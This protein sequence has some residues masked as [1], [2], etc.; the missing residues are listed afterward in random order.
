MKKSLLALFVLL[1]LTALCAATP[2]VSGRKLLQDDE[3]EED[4]DSDNSAPAPSVS[5]NSILD[6]ARQLSDLSVFYRAAA[7]AGL[8]D[9]L[10][11]STVQAT[12]F[13]PT[14]DALDDFLENFDLTRTQFINTPAFS[15]LVL[16]YHIVPS[17]ALRASQLSDNQRLT[18][19]LNNYRITINTDRDNE[20]DDDSD[21]EV[22]A[23][24]SDA[25]IERADI[26]AG[27][28]IVHTIG[29]V[30]IPRRGFWLS[31][32]Q[33]QIGAPASG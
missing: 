31:I 13:A 6:A 26:V 2:L 24:H 8:N 20:D 15:R 18:T 32:V 4:G 19:A 11:S 27:Q 23:A 3:D 9:T 10:T 28:A 25:E 16:Q 17:S 5:G 33:G 29:S 12:V 21:I 7:N 30:L 22:Q 14:D 1:G